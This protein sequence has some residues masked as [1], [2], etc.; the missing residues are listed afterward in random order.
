MEEASEKKLTDMPETEVNADVV[1]NDHKSRIQAARERFL[2]RKS[3][4]LS[5]I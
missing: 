4:K 5:K 1:A 3:N 2:A